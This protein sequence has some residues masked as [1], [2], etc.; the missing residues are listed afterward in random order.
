MKRSSVECVYLSYVSVA[1]REHNR[2]FQDETSVVQTRGEKTRRKN[3]KRREEGEIK[4]NFTIFF[5][6]KE[7]IF[8]RAR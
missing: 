2:F 1:R 6:R 3:G 8:H 5:F 7:R 4:K